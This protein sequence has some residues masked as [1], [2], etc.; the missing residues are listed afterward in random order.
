MLAKR[1]IPCLDIKDGRVVK[2]VNFLDLRDA[3]DPVEQAA[4]YDAEGADELIFLDITASHERRDIVAGHGAQGGRP[5]HHP[6]HRGRRPPR[7]WTT[8]APSSWPAPTRCRSTPPPSSTPALI[9]EGAERF[10]SQ[11]IVVAIDARRAGARPLGGLHPRRPHAPP[12]WTPWSGPRRGVAA[13]AGEI[14]LTSMDA[15]GTQNGYD[16]ELTRAVAD[17]VDIPVIASG[18]AG[19]LEHFLRGAD[20]GRGRRRPGRQPLPLPPALR[21]PGQGVPAGA[22][23]ARC[24]DTGP[25]V[26]RARPGPGHRAGLADRPGAD[27]GLREPGGAGAHAGDRPGA[28]LEPQP[29]RALAQGRH[30]RALPGTSRRSATTATPTPC[31]SRWTRPAPPATPASAAASFARSAAWTGQ[32]ARA[33]EPAAPRPTCSG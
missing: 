32:P 17:A 1:I 12:A 19:S 28:L 18:G 15:D 22:G 29:R 23:G 26:G 21:G 13:G 3:G 11:C 10:G 33:R 4:V 31:S 6:V 9:R 16:L 25:Q 2:G 27:A 30:Q 7:A 8:C 5:A 14:L 20:G 24:D